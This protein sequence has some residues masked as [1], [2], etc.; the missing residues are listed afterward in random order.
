MR[1]LM[2]LAA[3]ALVAAAT[4][5]VRAQPRPRY[6]VLRPAAVGPLEVQSMELRMSWQPALPVPGGYQPVW[7]PGE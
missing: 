5:P 6:G 1:T 7:R 2:I 3:A 4:L